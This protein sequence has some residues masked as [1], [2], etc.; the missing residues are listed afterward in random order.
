MEGD[1]SAFRKSYSTQ[2]QAVSDVRSAVEIKQAL[3]PFAE[4]EFLEREDSEHCSRLCV[5]RF[6]LTANGE[7]FDDKITSREQSEGCN[8]VSHFRAAAASL[9]DVTLDPA[10]HPG[11]ARHLWPSD[12]SPGRGTSAAD[13]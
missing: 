13:R 4:W 11:T 2:C 8:E 5:Q 10:I 7:V 3:E 1:L 9:Q 6:K 12:T